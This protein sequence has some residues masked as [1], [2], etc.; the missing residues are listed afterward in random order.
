MDERKEG[1]LL[2]KLAQL[3]ASGELDKESYREQRNTILDYCEGLIVEIPQAEDTPVNGVD[4]PVIE[5]MVGDSTAM[6][7]KVASVDVIEIYPN[8]KRRW[9][10]II[11]GLALVVSIYAIYSVYR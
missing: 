10:L 6:R 5:R 3:Y 9:G 4:K 8:K 1:A 7:A 11:I 2:K